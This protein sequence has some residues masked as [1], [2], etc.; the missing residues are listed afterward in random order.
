MERIT[1][2]SKLFADY[3]IYPKV[4]FSDT[5]PVIKNFIVIIIIRQRLKPSWNTMIL[6]PYVEALIFPGGEV[7][8]SRRIKSSGYLSLVRILCRP[9]L[10]A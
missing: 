6:T 7:N 5:S 3:E 2:L 8:I 4:L 1:Q 10:G 9:T